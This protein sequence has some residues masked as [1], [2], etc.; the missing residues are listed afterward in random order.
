MLSNYPASPSFY[1]YDECP[2]LLNLKQKLTKRESQ[3]FYLL[4]RVMTNKK[5]ANELGISPRTVDMYIN[6][7]K[8]KLGVSYKYELIEKALAML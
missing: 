2:Q 5:I 4:T 6:Q 3:C 8:N 1:D 7:L